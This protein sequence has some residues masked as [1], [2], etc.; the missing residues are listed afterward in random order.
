MAE[1][2]D[3]DRLVRHLRAYQR[4]QARHRRRTARYTQGG[5]K[6]HLNL[7]ERERRMLKESWDLEQSLLAAMDE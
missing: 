1:P 7:S 4:A 3:N 2:L 6:A 5:R